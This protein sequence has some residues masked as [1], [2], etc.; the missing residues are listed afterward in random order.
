MSKGKHAKAYRSLL[1]YRGTKLLAAR[2]LFFVHAQ[3]QA[4]EELVK[5]SGVA[6]NANMFTRFVE[7]FTIPR[8]RRAV[9]ASF[10]V[11]IAQQ[12]CGSRYPHD[13]LSALRKCS[14]DFMLHSQ[15][16]RLLLL[17]GLF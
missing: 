1:R 4:E 12:M 8:M 14:T 15:H 11:M 3:M 10:V 7:I 9:L 17:N 16:H 2:E 5:E 13:T 6:V